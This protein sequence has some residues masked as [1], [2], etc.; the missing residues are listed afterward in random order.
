MS[1]RF[2]FFYKVFT[3]NV[4]ES[5]FACQVISKTFLVIKVGFHNWK[6]KTRSFLDIMIGVKQLFSNFAFWGNPEKEL[7]VFKRLE[8]CIG[9]QQVQSRLN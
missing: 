5:L 9:P 8:G 1:D 6:V 2:L 7:R 4:N 3:I